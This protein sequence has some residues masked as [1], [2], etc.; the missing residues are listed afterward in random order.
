MSITWLKSHWRPELLILTLLAALTRF[1]DVFNPHTTVFDEVYF[2]AFAGHYLTGAYFFDIHPPLGKLLLAGWAHLLGISGTALEGADP[3]VALRLLPALAG[4]LL[5][6]VFYLFLRQ[7]KASRLVATLGASL[8]LLDNA[9]LVESRFI[10]IDTM[11]LLFG[12]GAITLYLAARRRTG[13]AHWILLSLSATLAGAAAATK[14]TGLTALG[15]IGLAWFIETPNVKAHWRRLL[16]QAAILIIVPALV[17]MAAFAAHFAL[18]TRSG[19]GDAFMS[20]RYQSTLIGDAQYDPAA[21]MSFWD[22]FVELNT[23]MHSSEASLKTVTHPYGSPWYSWPLLKRPIYYWAG[24]TAANGHQGNIYLMGNPLIWWG[25]LVIIFTMLLA[26]ID[27]P[28][29]FRSYRFIIPFLVV[30][31]LA[32]FVPFMFIDRVMFLYHYFFAFL[33][34][35]AIAVLGLGLMA[36][37]TDRSDQFWH[38]PSRTSAI[39][40][41]SVL[42]VALAGFLFF[43]PLS[44][45]WSISPEALQHRIWLPTWR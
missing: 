3:G 37:W 8:L 26:R 17:Y 39:I 5:I 43:A 16:P 28:K 6:P 34:S 7:L 12:L 35:L 33:F 11:L 40:Y 36:G 24:D 4:A 29:L 45:G 14:W 25:V 31:Y 2:K 20:P 19:D 27:R 41:G 18:L 30:A 32:N 1:W 13:R 15:L 9:F 23:V 44:Y 10:L 38:F 42:L 21:R 22:R